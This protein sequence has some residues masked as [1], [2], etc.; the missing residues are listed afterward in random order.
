MRINRGKDIRHLVHSGYLLMVTTFI[1]VILITQYDLKDSYESVVQN[2][3]YLMITAEMSI[4][5]SRTKSGEIINTSV[6]L[7]NETLVL[8]F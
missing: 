3:S 2:P 8:L 1:I 4:S 5:K 7:G 6:G